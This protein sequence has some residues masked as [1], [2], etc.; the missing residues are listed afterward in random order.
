MK[1]LLVSI[2]AFAVM[3]YFAWNDRDIVIDAP[4]EFALFE[5]TQATPLR[6]DTVKWSQVSATAIPI[7]N[8]AGSVVCLTPMMTSAASSVGYA[9]TTVAATGNSAF[10]V[11]R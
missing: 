6:S 7:N 1:K 5:V 4:D 2:A 11:A 3:S 10:W 8:G 9:V